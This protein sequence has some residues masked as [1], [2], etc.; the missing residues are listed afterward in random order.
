M[1]HADDL[2]PDS[3]FFLGGPKAI[4][5]SVRNYRFS[6]CENHP[7]WWLNSDPV[8]TAWMNALSGTFPRGE[9]YFIKS[10]KINGKGAP[11][12]LAEDIRKFTKQEVLHTREHLSFNNLARNSG[13]D[14]DHI[15][16]R[17]EK[18]LTSFKW[19]PIFDLAATIA[20]EHY[21]AMMGHEFLRNPIHLSG[22]DRRV[23]DLWRW[24]AVEE[25]EH[26]G[27]AFD[28]FLHATR[29]WS[30]LRRWTLRTGMM[31]LVTFFFL[32]HRIQDALEFLRQDGCTGNEARKRLFYFLFCKPGILRA[33]FPVWLR[34]FYPGFH[35]W[36]IDDRALIE[37]T[38]RDLRRIYG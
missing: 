31:L 3:D 30:S 9:S 10:V 26:K 34:Y 11:P 22:G 35:P 27:V 20:L 38:D 17:V 1:D 36:D 25:I 37:D 19:P 28:T 15:D 29:S 23:V 21:T 32:S 2:L 12:Q 18:L 24:H 16:R 13:Y 7:R 4:R 8:A 14:M 6:F 5:I 33:M